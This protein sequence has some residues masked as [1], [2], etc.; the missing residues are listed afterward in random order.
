MLRIGILSFAHIHAESYASCLKA[1]DDVDLVGIADEDETRG[2]GAAKKFVTRYFKDYGSLLKEG[3]D[4]ALICSENSRHKEIALAA[5][6]AKANILCEKPI[7]TTVEDSQEMIGASEREGVRLQIAFPCRFHPAV[8]R[9]KDIIGNGELGKVLAVSGTNRGVMPGGWFTDRKLAGGGAVIDHTV[10]VVDLIRWMIGTEIKSVYAETDTKFHKLDVDDCGIISM[11]FDNGGFATLDASWS[12]PVKAF[13]T[14]GDVTMEITGTRGLLSLDVFSQN[15]DLYSNDK[16]K[17][18][19]VN[20]GSN[21]DVRLIRDWIDSIKEDRPPS[22]TGL[23]GLRA[24]EV[25]LAAYS[26]ADKGEPVLIR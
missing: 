21:M 5:A 8:I 4:G 12:R 15:I 9:A 20:W 14:W 11:D 10:H 17:A 23:D 3:L 25:A 1:L 16:I 13:P 24:L 2:K 6:S 22:V 26:S 18:E 7:A 19:W